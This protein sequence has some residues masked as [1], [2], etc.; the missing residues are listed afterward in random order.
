[1]KC[2]TLGSAS[3]RSSRF[4]KCPM[5]SSWNLALVVWTESCP[6][7]NKIRSLI[8]HTSSHT[9]CKLQKKW[10][11]YT[12]SGSVVRRKCWPQLIKSWKTLTPTLS[13]G[14]LTTHWIASFVLPTNVDNKNLEGVDNLQLRK[15]IY[16]NCRETYENMIDHRSYAHKLS[17]CEIKAW[18][19]IRPERD[20]NP[21]TLRY[22]Y[23]ALPIELS[24]QLGPALF[25][26]L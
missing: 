8:I 24:S 14:Y 13:N 7:Y 4:S 17:S 15:F 9:Y 1:M 26:S 20:S 23:S 19:K 21:W 25:F 2:F 3:E 22:R 10:R 11:A 5:Y 6:A 12:E 16:L 18:K